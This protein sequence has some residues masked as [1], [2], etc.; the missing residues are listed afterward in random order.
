MCDARFS[1][2]NYLK[3]VFQVAW[4][5]KVLKIT[6]LRVILEIG[7]RE[8]VFSLRLDIYICQN[9]LTSSMEAP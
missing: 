5:F 1:V 7:Q 9:V 3:N 8:S 4:D 6:R 2:M